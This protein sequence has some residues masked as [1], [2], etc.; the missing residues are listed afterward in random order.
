MTLA[1]LQSAPV[2][3]W[4]RRHFV[5]TAPE[6]SLLEVDRIMRLTR[7]RHLPV[8]RDGLL[9]GIVSHRDVAPVA[10]AHKLVG[11]VMHTGVFCAEP[12]TPLA[13][14]ARRMLGR[15]IG[16]LVVVRRGAR[17]DEAIGLITESDLLRVAY[18]P[19]FDAASD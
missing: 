10:D 16:C 2:A 11:D 8:L 6:E 5:S 9:V 19:D 4:M 3:R 14:A 1:E 7:I 13:E 17:G 12:L 18:A 15:K